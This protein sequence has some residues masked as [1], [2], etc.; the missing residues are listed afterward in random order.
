[1]YVAIAV[2]ALSAFPGPN[3][4]LGTTWI[5]APLLGVADRH[6]A[7]SCRGGSAASLR[8]YV[9]ITGALILLAAVTTSDL[10]LLAARLLAR[11]ARPAAAEL[12]SAEPARARLAAGDPRGRRDLVGDRDRDRVV[13]AGRRR[14]PREPLLVRR[15]A[16]V[17][18]GAARGD[19]AADRRARPAAAVPRAV[20]G[21][22]PRQRDP[23]AGDRR[24]GRRRSRSGSS[25]WRRIPARATP[26]RSG[27]LAG[28]VVFV[29]VR[30][31]ARRGPARARRG[32]RRASRSRRSRS[33][34]GSSSR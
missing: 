19:Q 12:R 16:R 25:R 11:R 27:S 28:L 23:A 21:D 22:D 6:R 8:F 5:R 31:V 34:S 30:L 3:T 14:V 13:Q 15:A 32:A 29:S 20:P 4:E 10:R 1:M 7:T 9:G 17:H 24:R 33:S 18:G 26:G 2:V